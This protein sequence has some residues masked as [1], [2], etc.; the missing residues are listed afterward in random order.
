MNKK[1]NRLGNN[2][3]KKKKKKMMLW[4]NRKVPCGM[5]TSKLVTRGK[6]EIKWNVWK[7]PMSCCIMIIG[8]NS[9]SLWVKNN[10]VS[11]DKKS[12]LWL[13]VLNFSIFFIP[14]HPIG[15]IWP[16]ILTWNEMANHM[17]K[18]TKQPFNIIVL[19]NINNSII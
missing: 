3:W 1:R 9:E 18:Q 11:L 4:W 14:I 17:T 2:C 6:T 7:R 19:K 12:Y 15:Y 16:H 10:F 8:S 13:T 5:F